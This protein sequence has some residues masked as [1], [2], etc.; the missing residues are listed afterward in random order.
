MSEKLF[1]RPQLPQQLEDIYAKLDEEITTLITELK[2][3]G[4]TLHKD[5][6]YAQS[7]VLKTSEEDE[8]KVIIHSIGGHF[9]GR[10]GVSVQEIHTGAVMAQA[11]FD[12]FDLKYDGICRRVMG[13]VNVSIPT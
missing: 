3:I 6:A 8:L 13:L 11:K 5:N 10:A 4:F 9:P 1:P 12:T 7:Y 2:S